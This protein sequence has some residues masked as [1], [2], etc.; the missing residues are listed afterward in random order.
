M[1]MKILSYVYLF[2]VRLRFPSSQSVANVIRRRYGDP[3]LSKIRK[4]E[5]LD[6][7]CKKCQV[8]ITFLEVCIEEDLIPNFVQFRTANSR[9]RDT[10]SYNTCQKLLLTQELS[11]KKAKLEEDTRNFIELKKELSSVVSSLDFLYV[12]SLFLE[13]NTRTIEEIESSQNIKLSK[14]M[15]DNPKHEVNDLIFN[16][17]SHVLTGSQ[18]SILMKGLNYALPPKSLKHEDYLLNFELLFRSVNAGNYC[19]DGEMEHFRLDLANIA[20]SSLKFYNRKKKKL[21]NITEEEHNALNQ[22]LSLDDIIIQKADKGNVIVVLDRSTYIDK[23]ENILSD[24]SKF[25]PITFEEENG[26]L[27]YILEKEKEI[28]D[29]LQALVGK[30]VITAEEKKKMDPTGSVPGT[31]YG[32]CKVHKE[33]PIGEIPPMRPILSAVDTPS[34]KLENI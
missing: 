31:L 25:T 20:Y 32:N 16:F 6:F 21:E 8:D 29:F 23:M 13:K 2:L 9:L 22:L 34:Y 15:K 26:D 30:G 14:L 4:F 10:Q 17:S 7:R 18:E 12:T 3:V 33:V 19:N 28:K 27:K 24:V 5:K 1:F 11:D